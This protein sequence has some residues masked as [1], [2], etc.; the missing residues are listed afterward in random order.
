MEAFSIKEEKELGTVFRICLV[1]RR[2]QD[3][4]YYHHF[5]EVRTET[6]VTQFPRVTKWQ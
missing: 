4:W 1:F 2:P 5:M 6:E 3:W